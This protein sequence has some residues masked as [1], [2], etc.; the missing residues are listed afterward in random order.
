MFWSLIFVLKRSTAKV[1]DLEP[2]Y[3]CSRH[4]PAHL[5][6]PRTYRTGETYLPLD[7]PSTYILVVR[8]YRVFIG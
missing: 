8:E 4:S 5:F 6:H 7:P 3:L 2:L 1:L